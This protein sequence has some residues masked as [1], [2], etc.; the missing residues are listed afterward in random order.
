MEELGYSLFK[1]VL[2]DQ[3]DKVLD[4]LLVYAGVFHLT[5]NL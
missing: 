4:H 1:V 3:G 2:I 5:N